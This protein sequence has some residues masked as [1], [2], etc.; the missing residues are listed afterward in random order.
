MRTLALAALCVALTGCASNGSTASQLL[1]NLQ[2]C[3][4]TYQ[5]NI[6]GLGL[7]QGIAVTIRCEPNQGQPAPA[8]EAPVE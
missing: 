3:E 1:S 7:G 8:A 5:G 6:G 2:G 4:R